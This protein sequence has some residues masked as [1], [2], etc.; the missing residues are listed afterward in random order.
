MINGLGSVIKSI[1]GKLNA[2]DAEKLEEE[3]RKMPKEE[4]RVKEA[5]NAQEKTDSKVIIMFKNLTIY[6]N[7]EMRIRVNTFINNYK[8]SISKPFVEENKIIYRLE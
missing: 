4:I 7:E 3:I 1:T 8:N 2:E 5:M 6:I